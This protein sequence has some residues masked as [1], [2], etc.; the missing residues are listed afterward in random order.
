MV[1]DNYK[2]YGWDRKI[3]KR[4][5]GICVYVHNNLIVDCAIYEELN[6]SDENAEIFIL[7]INQKCTKPFLVIS[8]YRPPQGN[9]TL[10]VN[11]IRDTLAQISNHNKTIMLGDF[12]ID[13]GT[14]C[15]KA[16][17]GLKQLEREFNLKQYITSPTRVTTTSDTIIDHV[18]SNVTDII[19]SG[20]I[21]LNVSDHFM[22]FVLIKKKRITYGT[23]TFKCR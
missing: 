15:N 21:Q 2:V 3:R 23:T 16:I 5:G 12:N 17:R 1:I 20:T 4:G 10:F 22:I 8:I 19:S 14:A 9:Q 13:Y 7:Q 11:T 18:Y 6:V